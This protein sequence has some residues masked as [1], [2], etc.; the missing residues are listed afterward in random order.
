M[1]LVLLL[2]LLTGAR[3]QALGK[4]LTLVSLVIG[5]EEEEPQ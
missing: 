5:V 1:E 2:L 3:I 4:V